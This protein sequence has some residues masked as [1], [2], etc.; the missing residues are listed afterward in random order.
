MTSHEGRSVGSLCHATCIALAGRGIL[1]RGP[2][3][4]GKSDLALRLIDTAGR[5]TGSAA[6][7]ARLVADDQVHLTRIGGRVVA[8]APQKLRDLIEIRGLGIVRVNARA[9]APLALVVD[10]VDRR[11]IERLPEE[12]S[13]AVVEG[14]RLPLLRLDPHSASATARVRAGLAA[15]AS[16]KRRGGSRTA[17]HPARR[18]TLRRAD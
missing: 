10:L 7:R 6:L 12:R 1:I 5:G 14:V 4:S 15:L 17:A 8:R 2:S 16:G 18:P 9:A 13:S 3:G 11:S